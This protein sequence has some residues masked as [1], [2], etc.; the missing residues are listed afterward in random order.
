MCAS[1]F[2][3]HLHMTILHTHKHT[4]KCRDTIW[5]TRRLYNHTAH[6][7]TH[8]LYRRTRK[9]S[10][11]VLLKREQHHRSVWPQKTC[12]KR[13]LTFYTQRRAAWRQP[14]LRSNGRNVMRSTL[15]CRG[16]AVTRASALREVRDYCG[17]CLIVSGMIYCG[18]CGRAELNYL[19]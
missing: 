12:A 13:T 7:C 1:E 4:H 6:T 3:G 17:L 5:T 10:D 14:G 9:C 19:R 15:Q 18:W 2:S 11:L 16:C 8:V